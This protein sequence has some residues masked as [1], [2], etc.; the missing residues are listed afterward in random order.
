M[1]TP[2]KPIIKIQ[3]IIKT[4]EALFMLFSSILYFQCFKYLYQKVQWGDLKMKHL[5]HFLGESH[6]PLPTPADQRNY[7]YKEPPLKCLVISSEC[8][9]YF[10]RH[11]FQPLFLNL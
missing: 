1:N 11:M 10:L 4:S 5:C 3:S 6:R 7:S 9:L 2:R 8:Y